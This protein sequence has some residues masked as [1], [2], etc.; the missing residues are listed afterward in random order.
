M[1]DLSCEA[2]MPAVPGTYYPKCGRCD[3]NGKVTSRK[4]LGSPQEDRVKLDME[5]AACHNST[6]YLQQPP[7]HMAHHPQQAHY[8]C[9]HAHTHTNHH[10]LAE[11]PPRKPKVA[12]KKV[13]LVMKKFVLQSLGCLRRQLKPNYSTVC[14]TQTDLHNTH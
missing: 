3:F 8:V 9:E 5:I 6:L 12:D 4:L 2:E 14:K 7:E 10:Q 13:E 11:V 1:C